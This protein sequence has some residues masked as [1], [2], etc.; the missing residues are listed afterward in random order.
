M[1]LY[2]FSLIDGLLF[3]NKE[4]LE[5]EGEPVQ[6]DLGDELDQR[7]SREV[8]VRQVLLDHL[9]DQAEMVCLVLLGNR[10]QQGQ[11]V[12]EERRELLVQEACQE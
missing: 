3:F 7:V 12:R 2:H 1:N 9:V 4:Q 6:M 5:Y 11:L 10:D 8:S